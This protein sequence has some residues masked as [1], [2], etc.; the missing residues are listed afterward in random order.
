MRRRVVVVGAGP[1]GSAASMALAAAGIETILI[2]RRPM[3]RTKACGGGLSP[4]TLGFL[5]RIGAGA[6]VRARAFPIGG[7]RIAGTRRGG[8]VEL[9]GGDYETAVLVRSELDALL[10]DE[11]VRRGAALRDG[12]RVDGLIRAQSRVVAVATD[13]EIIECDAVVDASGS[14]GRLVAADRRGATLHTFMGWYDGVAGT[15][16]L[17]ELYFD[18]T[19]KPHY[20]WVFPESA[21]RVNIGVCFVPD[22]DGGNARER[23]DGFVAARLGARL[24]G[25]DRV[26]VI[27]HPV[28][29]SARAQQLVGDGVVCAGEAGGLAD[30]ATAEGI[31]HALVSGHLAGTCL[32]EVLAAGTTPTARA[33]AAYPRAVRRQLG[34]RLAGGW[35]LMQAL[36]TPVLD[37]ALRLGGHGATRAAITRAFAGLYHG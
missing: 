30:F 35:A 15:S 3:P 28:D 2:E 23:F 13:G 16:D 31:Y 4:W 19:V 14:N 9:R 27:G 34:L 8:E 12:V 24:A 26:A 36:R 10:A 25:A 20:G 22:R 18:D 11:A 32:A 21:R 5:D 33:L 6:R 37:A 7:A 29:V 17:V 1:A